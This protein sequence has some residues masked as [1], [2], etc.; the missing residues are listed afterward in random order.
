MKRCAVVLAVLAA[1]CSGLKT[2]PNEAPRN[3]RVATQ[4]DRGVRSALHVHE[5]SGPCATRYEGTVA[6]DQ[7]A[8]EVGVPAERA[9]YVVVSFDTSSFLGGSRGTSV[10]TVITPRAGYRYELAVRYRH[11]MYDVALREVDR[12]GASRELPRRGLNGC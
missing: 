2:Y 5:V 10:G 6:L 11:D 7:P 4:L 12:K 9:S 3:L 1:G 8:V